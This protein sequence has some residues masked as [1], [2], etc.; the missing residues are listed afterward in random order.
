MKKA[1]LIFN[2]HYFSRKTGE[3]LL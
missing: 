3:N 1:L 2:S